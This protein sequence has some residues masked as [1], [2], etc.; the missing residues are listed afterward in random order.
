MTKLDKAIKRQIKV[1]GV[2][3]DITVRLSEQGVEMSIPGTKTWISADWL[4]V[5]KALHTPGNVPSYLEGRPVE[6]LKH[7]AAKKGK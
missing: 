6:F 5:A 1:H 4:T 2:E 3:S 7:Q